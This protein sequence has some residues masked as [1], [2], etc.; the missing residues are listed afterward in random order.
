[1]AVYDALLNNR[2]SFVVIGGDLFSEYQ[3]EITN[4][5]TQAIVV[6]R[7]VVTSSTTISLENGLLSNGID[8][9][10]RIKTKN[11]TNE[12]EFSD[13]MVLKC[14]STAIVKITNIINDNGVN[15]IRNQRYLFEGTYTQS[16]NV[17]LK[18]YKY[19]FYKENGDIIKEY[20]ITYQQTGNLNQLVAF[21]ENGKSYK[22]KLV[23]IDQNDITTSSGLIEFLVDYTPPR[24][25][26]LISL[27]N[28]KEMASVDIKCDIRQLFFKTFGN[29]SFIN[30]AIDLTSPNSFVY[31]DNAFTLKND[32]YIQI[33]IHNY[34]GEIFELKN[35]T[36]N[37]ENI[38]RF[39]YSDIDNRFHVIKAIGAINIEYV[40]DVFIKNES[41][42][43]SVIIMQ[44]DRRID[45]VTKNGW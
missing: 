14:Y 8:Y 41:E 17:G 38:L 23:C 13:Y 28:N 21:L 42:L 45:I 44:K 25:R 20:P 18:G 16:N 4:L 26:Q 31:M 43:V 10:L 40:S 33:W 29:T 12:S 35:T 30:N 37:I 11:L 39:F 5:N 9:K 1:M 22:V 3:L 36:N 19:V 2:L 6:N 24:I 7:T 15:K 27:T 32:F 34:T